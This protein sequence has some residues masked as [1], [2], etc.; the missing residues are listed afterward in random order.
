MADC[1]RNENPGPRQ[2]KATA[3]VVLSMKPSSTL[4]NL[5]RRVFLG[6]IP[7]LALIPSIHAQEPEKPAPPEHSFLWK[8][9]KADQATSYLFG[10]MHTPDPR[11]NSLHPTVVEVLNAADAFYTELPMDDMGDMQEAVMKVGILPPEQNLEELIGEEA[12]ADLTACVAKYNYPVGMFQRMRPFLAEITLG[13]LELL[14]E[15]TSGKKALDERLYLVS[16]KKGKEVGGVEL[17]QEQIDALAHSRTEEETIDALKRTMKRE[18]ER[19]EGDPSSLARLTEAYLTGSEARVMALLE[20]DFDQ[21]NEGDMKFYRALIPVRNVRMADRTAKM[22]A[23]HAEKKYVFAFG[24]L[25]FMGEDGVPELL[26]AKGYTVT[27][28]LAPADDL[29][30]PGEEAKELEAVGASNL[31]E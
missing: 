14:P 5:F 15:L 6:L 28:M 4:P 27:R 21:T 31:S 10:T 26:R 22:M 17:L 25:H 30:L 16:Q 8:I 20:E 24:T 1:R 3:T 11:V 19:E 2:Q 9:E 23:E 12:W 29:S 7:G 18:L 13:Q